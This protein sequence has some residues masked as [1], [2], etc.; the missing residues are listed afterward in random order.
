MSTRPAH[1]LTRYDLGK[2]SDA[3]SSTVRHLGL[4][5]NLTGH[6]GSMSLPESHFFLVRGVNFIF[7]LKVLSWIFFPI[8]SCIRVNYETTF[9]TISFSLLQA[10][11]YR[12]CRRYEDRYHFERP[13]SSLQVSLSSGP[14]L[15]YP[16]LSHLE[17]FHQ[18]RR[19]RPLHFAFFPTGQRKGKLLPLLLA[20]LCL[21]FSPWRGP[22]H[23][24]SYVVFVYV[25]F[26]VKNVS[27]A[28]NGSPHTLGQGGLERS[29]FFW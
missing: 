28:P 21:R 20:V 10:S 9:P 23:F 29:R 8:S 6:V 26:D 15:G 7:L 17:P 5:P 25:L 27:S 19:G 18:E 24:A 13:F 4:S 11:L 1:T 14:L 12:C 22:V 2:F 16:H 3:F